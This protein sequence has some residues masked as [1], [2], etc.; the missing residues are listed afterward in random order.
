L[1]EILDD[2]HHV[3]ILHGD[4]KPRNMMICSR[5]KTSVLWVDFDCAQTFSRGDLTTKQENWVKEEDHMLDYFI[6]ALAIDY[7]QGKIDTTRSYYYD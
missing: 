2:I 6:Q 7:K 4:P 1:R 3:N 5:E